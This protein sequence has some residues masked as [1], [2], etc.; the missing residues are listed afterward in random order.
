MRYKGL[1]MNLLAALDVLLEERSVTRA[2]ERLCLSQS[3]TSNALARLRE[4][5]EDELLV[6]VGRRMV[7]TDRARN[8][9]SEL[10]EVLKRIETHVLSQPD[11]CPRTL[12]RNFVYMASDSA[13]VSFMVGLSRHLSQIAPLVELSARMADESPYQMLERGRID[14]LLIP[15]QF[16]SKEH[17]KSAMYEDQYCAVIDPRGCYGAGALTAGAFLAGRHVVVEIGQERKVPADRAIIEQ[18][19]GRLHAEMSTPSHLLVPWFVQGTDRIGTMP[20]RLATLIAAQHGLEIR[21]LPFPV[22]PYQMVM[23]WHGSRSNDAALKW[24]RETIAE[25]GELVG[26]TLSFSAQAPAEPQS[27]S[28]PR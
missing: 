15:E 5:L 11:F 2:S 25:Q 20:Y 28:A 24:L 26:R 21:P 9:Q 23:Q 14:L 13:S 3:A 19:H 1:D 4:T 8:I 22:P 18:A 12:K 17:P 27:A 6:R 16:A 7:L 10:N